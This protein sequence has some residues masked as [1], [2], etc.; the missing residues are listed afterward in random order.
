ML[1]GTVATHKRVPILVAPETVRR[2]AV[3][4]TTPDTGLANG[5]AFN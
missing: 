2:S 4:V 3:S 5:R 1:D